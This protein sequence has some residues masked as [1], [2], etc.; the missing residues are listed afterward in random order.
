LNHYDEISDLLLQDD[1]H[2]LSKGAQRRIERYFNQLADGLGAAKAEQR[3]GDHPVRTAMRRLTHAFGI[4]KPAFMGS[5]LNSAQW[6]LL[7][8]LAYRGKEPS[9]AQLSQRLSTP[10]NTIA[11][12]LRDLEN[13]KLLV[14]QA[15]PVDKRRVTLLLTTEGR[16]V[17]SQIERTASARFAK[18][19]ST[20]SSAEMEDFVHLL[21][22]FIGPLAGEISLAPNI[23]IYHIES[24]D[25][26]RTARAFLVTEL[27]HSGRQLDLRETVMTSKSLCFKL[28]I[29]RTL[30]AV[31]EVRERNGDLKIVHAAGTAALEKTVT[32]RKFLRESLAFA[33]AIQANHGERPRLKREVH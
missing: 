26:R 13:K 25:E 15:D 21:R 6:Q 17:I 33:H 11:T 19:L 4:L 20:F 16:A 10:G 32:Y 7:T 2:G 1:L 24:E 18:A 28:Q 14:R 30:G 22:L 31:T 3:K 27:V 8:E 29:D 5:S 12:M 23:V 9:I